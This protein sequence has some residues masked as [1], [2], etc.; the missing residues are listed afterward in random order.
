KK[1][2]E[3][4]SGDL[5]K[6][7]EYLRKKGASLAAKRA[8]KMTNEGAV[9]DALSDDRKKGVIVEIN[10]ETDF[11]AKGDDFQKFSND[12]AKTALD[13]N[14][15]DLDSLLKANLNGLSV[16]ET[17]DGL[18]GKLGEKIEIKKIENVSAED[19][20]ITD[21]IHFGSKLGGLVA[22]K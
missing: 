21:Y 11:V 6:A 22:F 5:E 17:L 19:G 7:I 14:I 18:M 12:V 15:S 16:Q 1:A 4:T 20:F 2:L 13:N 8:D 9:K 3:E 10:C